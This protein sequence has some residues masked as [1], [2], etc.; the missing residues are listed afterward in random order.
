MS[1]GPQFTVTPRT[2]EFHNRTWGNLE[3]GFDAVV[4]VLAA[5]PQPSMFSAGD[6]CHHDHGTAVQDV[7]MIQ[8]TSITQRAR[9]FEVH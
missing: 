9:D 1:V 8:Q 7:T 4:S 2:E 6:R 3:F 5:Q